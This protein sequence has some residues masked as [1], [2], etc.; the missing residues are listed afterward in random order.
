MEE[1]KRITNQE[2]TKSQLEEIEAAFK[3]C[4]SNH[5]GRIVPQEV[6]KACKQLGIFLCKPELDGIMKETDKSGNGYIE[7]KEF[8]EIV[9]EQMVVTN[10]RNEQLKKAFKRFDKDGDGTITKTEIKLV[11]KESGLE[12][13]DASLQEL[14]EEADTNKDGVISFDEFVHAVCEND[15][16]GEI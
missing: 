14:M 11:F 2:L 16:S 9:G 3:A 6:K 13:D 1:A 15:W 8:T 4:D 5:D 10:Y 12:L 7:L